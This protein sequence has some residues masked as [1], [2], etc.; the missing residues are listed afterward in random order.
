M[1]A[2]IKTGGKQYSVKVG[3]VVYVEKL[4]AEP[5]TTNSYTDAVSD[6]K[7]HKY[8]VT[9]VYDEGESNFSE[10][11]SVGATTGI[12]TVTT[13]TSSAPAAF[14]NIAGQRVDSSANG[15]TIVRTA[16]G[17]VLKVKRLLKVKR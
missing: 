13:D 10:E 16:D 11:L 17:R 2:V 6:S 5:V 12:T 4:N 3:D 15:I 14:Y 7:T 1:Y 9:A 8:K